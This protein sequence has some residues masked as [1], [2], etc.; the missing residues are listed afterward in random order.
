MAMTKQQQ[1]QILREAQ[2]ELLEA[3]N[4]LN[5]AQ[6]RVL[7]LQQVV[8]GMSGL[9]NP[10]DDAERLFRLAASAD[11][12]GSATRAANTSVAASA[13]RTVEH[14]MRR[15]RE[16]AIAELNEAAE[17]VP[18]ESSTHLRPR[19]AILEAMSSVANVPMLPR[20]IVELVREKG[21]FNE[22]LKSGSNGY[23]TALIRLSEDPTS[24]IERSPGGVYTYRSPSQS[25]QSTP[26]ATS[27][28]GV[29]I[30]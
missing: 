4:E 5:A 14:L 10:E 13:Q 25:D 18:V 23:T 8:R 30:D 19:D 20:E 2:A 9:L 12:A 22:G 11:I 24:P 3:R 27:L 28:E 1:E 29:D 16:A 15:R 6:R 26:T 7:N 21:L 17:S